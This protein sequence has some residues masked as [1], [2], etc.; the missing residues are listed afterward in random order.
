MSLSCAA[1]APQ[2][3]VCTARDGVCLV[4]IKYCIF[5]NGIEDNKEKHIANIEGKKKQMHPATSQS[6]TK[7]CI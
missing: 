6:A 1:H 4:Y 5:G 7:N 3:Y 2:I